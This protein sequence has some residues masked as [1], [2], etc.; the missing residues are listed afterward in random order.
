MNESTRKIIQLI[1]TVLILF[2]GIAFV[3]YMR[4]DFFSKL[5]GVVGVAAAAWITNLL[6]RKFFV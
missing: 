3:L 6:I 5:V 1:I 4:L 2:F